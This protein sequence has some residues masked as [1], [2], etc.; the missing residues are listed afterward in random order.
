MIE[1]GRTVSS[2]LS[3]ILHDLWRD[4]RGWILLSIAIGW[5]LALG[6][7]M[8]YPAVLPHVRAEFALD[9]SKAGLLLTVLWMGYASMQ[10]PGGIFGD[11]Y[12]ERA[13]LAVSMGVATVGVVAITVSSTAT[14]FFLS[15]LFVGIG[16]GLYGTTRLTALSNTYSERSG[17]AIGISQAAGNIGTMALPPLAGILAVTISWRWGFGIL[18]PVFVLVTVSLWFVIPRRTSGQEG[19]VFQSLSYLAQ[20]VRETITTRSVGIGTIC[21]VLMMFIYQSFTGFY[22]TYLVAEKDLGG[23]TA[24]VLL[25][26]FFA[27]AIIVQPIAGSA[28]DRWGARPMLIS[29]FLLT[30][31]FLYVLTVADTFVQLTIV[32]VL[33]SSQLAFWPIGNSYIADAVPNEV[34]GTG[35]G[36]VRTF[37]IGVGA[38]GPTIIGFFADQ[39]L[40]DEAFLA[41]AA[42]A[43]IG[44]IICL[45]LPARN[46]GA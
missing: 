35:F 30:T 45:R 36:L 24:S 1:H 29:V 37:Y 39:G 2:R 20:R 28:R 16:V 10:F 19:A 46:V 25:G 26:V 18:I 21:M 17:T 9:L 7:R 38:T 15:T 43:M 23:E 11:R 40:F 22:P 42:I 8:V 33:L 6:V 41:L 3:T 31:L 4:G 12:G 27:T 13:I 14:S 32:T 34:Q 5:L 44:G